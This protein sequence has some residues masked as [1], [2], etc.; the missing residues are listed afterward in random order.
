[1]NRKK[2]KRKYISRFV[3]IKKFV[4]SIVNARVEMRFSAIIFEKGTRLIGTFNNFN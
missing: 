4:K 1:M 3:I 2:I